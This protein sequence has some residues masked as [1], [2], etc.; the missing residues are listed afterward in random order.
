VAL[1]SFASMRNDAASTRAA[2]FLVSIFVSLI[3]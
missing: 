1:A 3:I 2:F